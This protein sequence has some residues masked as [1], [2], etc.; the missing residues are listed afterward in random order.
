VNEPDYG[1][2]TRR[3]IPIELE[4]GHRIDLPSGTEPAVVAAV[5]VRHRTSCRQGD[6]SRS[7]AWPSPAPWAVRRLESTR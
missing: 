6:A 5:L 4:C 7:G 2:G 1:P 3:E